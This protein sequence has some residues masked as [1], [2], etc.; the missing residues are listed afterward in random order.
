MQLV[1]PKNYIEIDQEEM[2]YLEGG[3]TGLYNGVVATG[4]NIAVNA[5][6]GSLIGGPSI[7]VVINAIGTSRLK[8]TFRGYALKWLSIQAANRLTGAVMGAIFGFMSFSV[9]SSLAKLWD[10]YDTNPNNGICGMPN[11]F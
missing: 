9:G 6:L 4:I 11:W 5:V 3:F 2:M 10:R 8:S 1:L 7:R